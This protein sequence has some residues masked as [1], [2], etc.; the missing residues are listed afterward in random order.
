L[1]DA[2]KTA[3][4]QYELIQKMRAGRDSVVDDKGAGRTD[5]R[6]KDPNTRAFQVLVSLICSVQT[7]DL[8]TDRI[9]ARLLAE[10]GSITIEKYANMTPEELQKKIKDMNYF[11]KKSVYITLA[12]QNIVENHDG[13]VP[14][15]F[16]EIVKMKGVGPKI[17]H[18][19]LDCAFGKVEG[20]AVDTHVHRISNILKWVDTKTPE[21][22]M[23]G[24]MKLF[25]EDYW[26]GFNVMLVGFGQ[27][28]CSSRNPD[29]ARCLLN[30]ECPVGKI[31]MKSP[32]K[33][34][35]KGKKQKIELELESETETES[36]SKSKSESESE[37]E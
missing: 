35:K 25:P 2:Q 30:N 26:D 8:I 37:S 24:L 21:H 34:G 20:I 6:S 17:A 28:I 9:M 10:K 12:A 15:D 33:K 3:I 5:N 13:I 18:I 36:E 27:S 31:N 32:Q 29:C 23:K 19:L 11:R 1:T 16:D 14:S 7:N 22:S 4:R